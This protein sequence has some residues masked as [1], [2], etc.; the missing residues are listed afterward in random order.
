MS[1]LVTSPEKKRE[2]ERERGK[3][4]TR[5]GKSEAVVEVG[6]ALFFFCGGV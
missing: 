6:D 4:E 5:V 3:K 2:R 1:V